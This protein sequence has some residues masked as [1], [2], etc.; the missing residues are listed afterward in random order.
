MTMIHHRAV[1]AAASLC[2]QTAITLPFR[3]VEAFTPSYYRVHG[4]NVRTSTFGL[5]HGLL[6]STTGSTADA[7]SSALNNWIERIDPLG[8]DTFF[9]N[10]QAGDGGGGSDQ[11]SVAYFSLG[12]SGSSYEL[13]TLSQMFN[14]ALLKQAN[15][16]FAD[17]LGEIPDEMLPIYATFAMDCSA[18]EASRLA[19]EQNGMELIEME[20]QLWG[21]VENIRLTGSNGGEV[22]DTLQDAVENGQW[23]PGQDFD[24][25][26]RNV[27]A[28]V[29]IQSDM[30][31]ANL[32]AAS[33]NTI[34]SLEAL[35]ADVDRRCNASPRE[36]SMKGYAPWKA[37]DIVPRSDLSL[38]AIN[39]DGS[40]NEMI[41]AEVMDA[42]R[43]HGYLI[44]DVNEGMGLS[45]SEQMERSLASMWKST[46]NFFDAAAKA[47]EEGGGMNWFPLCKLRKV[48]VHV[49][50]YLVIRR[51]MKDQC[52]SWRREY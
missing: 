19:L 25:V 22:F 51:M 24:C 1:V 42:L 12:I 41:G 27:K 16:R 52:V 50:P 21:E 40:E 8:V 17:T 15:N 29:S 13:G 45:E 20:D 34:D 26:V 5:N 33:A 38:D 39:F 9:D 32:N 43:N 18:K 35:A 11:S 48:L 28:R 49:T 44:V 23:K 6:A 7:S 47:T 2:L 3:A 14:T 37:P 31:A 36:A 30:G 4:N 46:E 10:K